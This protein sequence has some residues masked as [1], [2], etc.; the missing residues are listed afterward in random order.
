MR[1]EICYRSLLMQ[2]L[3]P[4]LYDIVLGQKL[5]CTQAHSFLS[6]YFGPRREKT[7]E[8]IMKEEEVWRR[9]GEI[10]FPNCCAYFP[11]K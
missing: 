10:H 5:N 7:E 2:T 3:P 9:V 1:Y 6:Q 4:E 8:E 11:T